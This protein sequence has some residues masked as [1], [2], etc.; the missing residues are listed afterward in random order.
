MRAQILAVR[1]VLA[2]FRKKISLSTVWFH[3]T[4]A[5]IPHFWLPGDDDVSFHSAVS[6]PKHGCP[7]ITNTKTQ[8]KDTTLG[9]LCEVNC[10]DRS[11]FY[12][13]IFTDQDVDE[14]NLHIGKSFD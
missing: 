2:K 11:F 4:S 8:H 5:A 3:T 10:N 14:K 7:R 6:E 1:H 12:W 9:I 13:T